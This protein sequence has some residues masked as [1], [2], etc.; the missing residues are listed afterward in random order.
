MGAKVRLHI[1]G[2]TT[3]LLESMGRLGA[4]MIDLDYPVDLAHARA[5]MGPRQVIA[6]N[7]HP[8]QIMKLGSPATITAALRDCEK[9]GGPCW[10]IGAGCEIPRGTPRE[11]FLAL[12]RYGGRDALESST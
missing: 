9:A 12:T 2:N 7:L 5:Q 1:C 11:N 8:V 10:A 3:H 6:G 4:D